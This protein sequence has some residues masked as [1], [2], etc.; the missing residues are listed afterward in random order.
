MCPALN[1]SPPPAGGL[2]LTRRPVLRLGRG[3][4]LVNAHSGPALLT[5]SA[6]H[7]YR[8]IS[9]PRVV[10]DSPPSAAPLVYSK[11]SFTSRG[12]APAAAPSLS[13]SR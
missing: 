9:G 8:L 5:G 10:V 3:D 13:A 11:E 7:A 12:R 6:R 2:T 1:A 4:K